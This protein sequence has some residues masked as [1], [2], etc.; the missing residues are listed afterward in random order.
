MS[1]SACISGVACLAWNCPIQSITN[2][3]VAA[4]YSPGEKIEVASIIIPHDLPLQPVSFSSKWSYLSGISL[5]DPDLGHPGCIDLLG[6]GLLIDS[7]LHGQQYGSLLDHLLC[8]K[9][10]LDGSLLAALLHLS[11]LASVPID[12]SQAS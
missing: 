3:N 7:M 5:A 4:V 9:P 6:V 10:G 12:S 8:L 2:F 1:Q 11:W